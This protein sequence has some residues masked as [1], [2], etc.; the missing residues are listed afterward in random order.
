MVPV[1]GS[2]RLRMRRYLPWLV[3]SLALG[4]SATFSLVAH[5]QNHEEEGEESEKPSQAP[6]APTASAGAHRPPGAA[7]VLPVRVPMKDGMVRLAGA[8]FTMGSSDKKSAPNEQPARRATVK[9]FWLDRTEVTVGAYRN[10]VDRKACPAPKDVSVQCTYRLGDADLP[11]NCVRFVDAEAYC[12]FVAKRL[13]REAEW[14]Y[15]ARG[16]HAI[17]YPWG[18]GATSCVTAATLRSEASGRT[19]TGDRPAK[20]GTHGTGASP[21]GILDLAGNVEE[22]VED[23]YAES[24]KVGAPPSGASHVLRGGSWLL[25]P[26]FA[27][28]T[29]RNWGSAAEAGPSVGFRCARDEGWGAP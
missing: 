4:S 2:A 15:A 26:S 7:A 3:V 14:E 8:T 5:A 19:C 24:L 25:P 10:C 12:R 22:W 6:A 21:F 29:A 27:R 28:T 20:V 13:P 9:P 18:T 11:I 17:R 16:T 23:F 1:L